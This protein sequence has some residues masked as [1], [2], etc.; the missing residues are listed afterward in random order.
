MH[1]DPE[2][3]KQIRQRMEEL[4]FSPSKTVWD[5]LEKEITKEKRRRRPLLWFSSFLALCVAGY[6]LLNTNYNRHDGSMSAARETG[7]TSSA[8]EKNTSPN[9]DKTNSNNSNDENA[10][11]NG[12]GNNNNNTKLKES[13]PTNSNTADQLSAANHKKETINP[14]KV[15]M[16]KTGRVVSESPDNLVAANN[17]YNQ[18]DDP[19]KSVEKKKMN[20][21]DETMKNEIVEDQ[22]AAN[23]SNQQNVPNSKASTDQNKNASVA[24]KDDNSKKV[25]ST[26]P[27]SKANPVNQKKKN[28]TKRPWEFGLT[29]GAGESSINENLFNTVAPSRLDPNAYTQSFSLAAAPPRPTYNAPSS[30]KG[31]FSYAAG[32]FAQ[33]SFS[34]RMGFTIGLNYHYASVRVEATTYG[35]YAAAPQERSYTNRYH[36]L[37]LPVSVFYQFNK[38]H[39]FPIIWEAGAT[40]GQLI[41]S[42]AVH[43]NIATGNYFK[44]NSLFNRTQINAATSVMLGIHANKHLYFQVG[45]QV[46]YGLT[47]LLKSDANGSQHLFFGGVKFVF[48]PNKK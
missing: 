24:H 15:N 17:I 31:A 16:N 5:N 25:V 44:D 32:L 46:Q 2:F 9:Q 6:F 33:K 40:V 19:S 41:G 37:E 7:A 45:P 39:R 14:D 36:F 34:D 20:P 26:K 3:E 28:Q 23:K 42:D 12:T 43:Y 30:V 48:I 22:L 4:K 10:T 8:Q 38:K 13:S 29:G 1:E 27:E 11:L 35:Y 18:K 21:V 47:N